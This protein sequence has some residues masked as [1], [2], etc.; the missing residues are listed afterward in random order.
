MRLACGADRA[1]GEFIANASHELRTPLFSL[2]GFLELLTGD[3]E[4]DAQTRER[5]LLAMREQV[6]RLTR[7]ATI[8]LL[9][10]SRV[11]AGRDE[12]GE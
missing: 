11:D 6:S 7:L 2:A 8:V 5:F 12:R 9:D 10:L 1:R 4:L 3:D